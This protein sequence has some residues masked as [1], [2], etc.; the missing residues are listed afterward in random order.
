MPPRKNEEKTV[1]KKK[2]QQKKKL[3]VRPKLIERNVNYHMKKWLDDVNLAQNDFQFDGELKEINSDE[4]SDDA[5]C[6]LK[7]L[8]VSELECEMYRQLLTNPYLLSETFEKIAVSRP[9]AKS[10]SIG[11][12]FFDCSKRFPDSFVRKR[13]SLDCEWD[14]CT[15]ETIDNV[16]H[17]N[18]VVDHLIS[19]SK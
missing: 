15:F 18:H 12:T 10:M 1:K 17:N 5:E 16:A 7:N 13:Y 11:K 3:P 14:K 6:N 4:E 19:M 2:S 9:S 8:E